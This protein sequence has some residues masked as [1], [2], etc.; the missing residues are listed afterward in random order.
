[1]E[2]QKHQPPP[3]LQPQQQM[4][5][6]NNA[7]SS[8]LGRLSLD[9]HSQLLLL[10]G[11][12]GGGTEGTSPSVKTSLLLEAA[13]DLAS[14]CNSTTSNTPTILFK[15]IQSNSDFPP[16]VRPNV[17]F[18]QR[19]TD[20]DLPCLKRIRVHHY[21]SEADLLQ[22]LWSLQGLP[23][24]DRPSAGILVDDLS[25]QSTHFAQC[26][27]VLADTA[28]FLNIPAFVATTSS[29]NNQPLPQLCASYINTV[30]E[31]IPVAAV[32]TGE[33]S[34][35]PSFD[36]FLLSGKVGTLTYHRSDHN[37][38]RCWYSWT[39]ETMNGGDV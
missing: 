33:E 18:G 7:S 16:F 8:M 2:G 35:N 6:P 34:R 38:H 23:P 26:I 36:V 17:V 14:S 24:M 39:I 3:P 1:M 32:G 27:A 4:Q 22:G 25:E 20:W 29:N 9:L 12:G 31:L 10:R 15:R 19:N 30:L 28:R 5:T 37:H 13:L 11:G 21:T